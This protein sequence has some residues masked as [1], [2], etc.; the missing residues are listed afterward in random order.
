MTQQL[1]EWMA[2]CRNGDPGSQ[3]ALY[4]HYYSLFMSICLRYADN[5]EDAEE[6][7]QN[8]F[9][10]IFRNI[11]QYKGEG[12][13]E[14]WMKRILVNVA[15]DHYRYKKNSFHRNIVHLN[16]PEKSDERQMDD[17]MYSR[18]LHDELLHEDRYT[19]EELLLMLQHLPET[20]RLVFNLYV[21]EE[22]S[23][24]EIGN[25]IGLAERT[26][27]F[28]LNQARRLLITE[29][30]KKTSQATLKRV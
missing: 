16:N 6:M 12:S 23:H 5:R 11:G 15:L 24:K 27:Q 1:H 3:K 4:R 25:M 7:L 8:G 21:F 28:H 22:Y 30:E 26:S 19:K 29:L 14:G 18:G 13:F 2:G 17:M 10:K 9:L 20:T